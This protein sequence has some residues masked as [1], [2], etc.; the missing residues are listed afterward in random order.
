MDEHIKR[1]DKRLAVGRDG[2]KGVGPLVPEWLQ[3]S[4]QPNQQLQR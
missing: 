1:Y 2:C 3:L 4:T